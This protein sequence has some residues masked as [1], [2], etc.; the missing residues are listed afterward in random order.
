MQKPRPS[1]NA[2][3]AFEA[4][5]RLR[6]ITLGEVIRPAAPAAKKWCLRASCMSFSHTMTNFRQCV[7]RVKN[8]SM[9]GL[10]NPANAAREFFRRFG[11]RRVRRISPIAQ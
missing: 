9:A 11:S 2:L 8:A 10:S 6:S 5:A 7:R 3:R 1:L 4:V